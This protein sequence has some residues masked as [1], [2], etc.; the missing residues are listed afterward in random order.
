VFTIYRA[1]VQPFSDREI[2]LLSSFADQAVIAIEN[3]RLLEEVQGQ[4]AELKQSLE[5]QIATSDVLNVISRSPASVE[6]VLD[7]IVKTAARLCAAEYAF[8][9]KCSE[10]ECRLAAANRMDA[11][12][13]QY[14][15]RN[16][17][18]I[19]RGSV[20]GRVALERRTL[21]VVDVLADPD[22]NRIEWQKVGKQRT[23]LGVPLLRKGELLGTIILART[24]V[25]PFSERQIELV[26][27]FADQ[28]V[29]AIE[30]ARLFEEVQ[31]RTRELVATLEYQTATGDVLSVISRSPTDLQPVLDTLAN[32]ACRLCE[33]LSATILLRDGDVVV[34]RAH[35]GPLLAPIGQ[36]QPLSRDWVTGRAVLESRTIHVPDMLDASAAE[37]PEGQKMA[38]TYGHRATLVCPLLRQGAAIGAI[39]VRRSEARAF[40]D[41]QVAL[42]ETFADQAV[43]AIENTR[44]FE[45]VQETLEQQTATAQVLQVISRSTFDLQTVLHTLVESAARL[46]DADKATITRQRDGVFYRAEFYGFSQEFMDYVRTVPVEAERGTGTG[47]ALLEG[48]IVHIPDVQ[49]DPD[50]TWSSAQKL[51]DYRTLLGVPMLREGV[52]IGV[53]TLTRS[54]PRPFTEKQMELVS[55]FADQ[56]AIAIENVRLFE[57]V[58]ARTDELA[59]SLDSLRAAQDRLVETQKLAALGQLTAGV[60]HEIKNP[61]NFVNNFADLSAELVEE[62]QSLLTPPVNE[63]AMAEAKDIA[64]TVRANLLKVVEHGRRADSIVKNMLLHSREG[65]GE[66]RSVDVNA[67]AQ[68]S[69]NL[70]YHGARAED[71][72]FNI[73]LS[74]ALD[75]DVGAIDAYPQELARV[76][77]NLVSNG[78][79]AARK[80]Q[81]DDADPSYEPEILVATRGLSD[82]IEIRVRDNGTGIGDEVRARMFD[83]FFTTKPPGEG[84]GLGLSLSHDI[85]VKQHGG[86]IDVVSKVGEFTEF[87]ITLPRRAS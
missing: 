68:E 30:N 46:C 87:V 21:H 1:E 13:M 28:A 2:A 72:S 83:P 34:P 26:T 50:Y 35:T 74:T 58:Q 40:S 15:S 62:L 18:R 3:A 31:A 51:G 16:P 22:F 70:A 59:Q 57:Q 25:E 60:A 78:F 49:A 44:L 63:D 79:H 29:I 47:R 56:A 11:E 24:K 77:L 27:T 41:G 82:R 73:R 86:R 37:Y 19:D 10:G 48:R 9:A 65:S 33:A 55:T 42:L 64:A 84:T 66:R 81:R 8:V 23:V 69:L 61:L 6:P 54:E 71:P 85:V 38:L 5:Y 39:L 12:H 32:S 43:I 75:L 17:V 36:R 52:P 14:L 20:T 80:R 7:A 76:L 45:E 53:L 4:S 67:A